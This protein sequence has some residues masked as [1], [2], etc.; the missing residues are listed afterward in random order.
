LLTVL[1]A[2]L[3]GALTLPKVLDAYC[4]LNAPPDGWSLVVIDNGSTD[5]T[6]AVIQRYLDRLPLHYLFEPQRGKNAALNT[7]LGFVLQ[8]LSSELL[9][10]SDDDA[11][12]DPDWLECLSEC[13]ARQQDYAVFG[14][15]ILP[16]WAAAPP[17]WLLRLVPLGLSFGLTADSLPDGPVHPG[18]VWGA[19]MAIRRAV[20]DSG[21]RFNETV[22]PNGGDYAMGS[23]IELT[24]KLHALGHL[25][26]FCPAARV[27]HH[28]RAHQLTRQFVLQRAWR[29]GRGK[30]RQ[31]H[32][33]VFPEW[34]GIPRWM[35]AR[36]LNEIVRF[37][38]AWLC[39]QPDQRF[40]HRWELAQLRGYFHE[41]RQFASQDRKS[42][43]ITSY[44]GELGGMELRMAQEARFLAAAGYRS[45]IA[46]PRFPGLD[47]WSERLVADNLVVSRWEVPPV[48][49]QWR[50]RRFN[51]LI[52]GFQTERRIRAFRASLV[53]VA[54]CWTSYGLTHLWLAARCGL[55]AVV[56]VHNCFPY[57]RMS[58]WHEP[59]LRQAFTA[60]RGIYAVSESAMQR[61]LHIFRAY[62]A[63]SVRLS[64]IPNTVDTA[65]FLPSPTR[66]AATRKALGIAEDALVIGSVGRLSPQKRPELLIDLHALLSQQ[67][68]QLVLVLAGSGPLEQQLRERAQRRGVDERTVFAG[69]VPSVERL[70]PALDLHLLM[71]RNEGFG[72]ATIEAMACG[73]PA[74]ATEVPGSLDILRGCDSGQ[75][76]PA[77]DLPVTAAIVAGLLL[78]RERRSRMAQ[79]ARAKAEACYSN[80]VVGQQ[81]RAF[82]DGLL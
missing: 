82:Y 31:E 9:A 78:D 64:V 61:F 46:V 71:S 2:T 65:R 49:E 47:A 79:A 25:S 33:G 72:I 30:R 57:E 43:L 42:V 39:R 34:L 38:V 22:G 69:F 18:L 67:F 81:V 16:D 76:V 28:I 5:G 55:P 35:L 37:A 21:H 77:N 45:V 1:M 52:A 27:R 54:M 59:L 8:N 12:P 10:F 66:R 73:V 15:A 29:Y 75:L 36:Y 62:L 80:A 17:D 3:N 14:G 24:R 11:A 74:V 7:G 56:S 68:P 50:W 32:P 41:S 48:F 19:N 6:Y 26:W 51:R 60:V 40:L 63:P 23:E 44:S 4:A 20:F 58:Q 13:A 53:H 70:L